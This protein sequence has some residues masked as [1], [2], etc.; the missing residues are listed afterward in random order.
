MLTDT[1]REPK[2][3]WVLKGD[4]RIKAV[5]DKAKREGYRVWLSKASSCFPEGTYGLIASKDE[6]KLVHFQMEEF[7]AYVSFAAE[8]VPSRECGSGY[9]IGDESMTTVE[10]IENDLN[11]A[12]LFECVKPQTDRSS[13]THNVLSLKMKMN[14]PWGLRD[15]AEY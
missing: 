10:K 2:H 1:I 11:M 14:D 8:L 13:H 7:N 12:A 15:Y 9:Y 5:A 3:K 4:I 6:Q